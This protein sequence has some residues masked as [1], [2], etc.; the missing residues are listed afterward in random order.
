VKRVLS[1]LAV[2]LMF[3]SLSFVVQAEELSKN[4]R[5]STSPIS[6]SYI[7]YDKNGQ[8]VEEGVVPSNS[9]IS[10]MYIWDGVT[11]DNGESASFVPSHN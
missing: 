2:F 8:I 1:V 5:E 11:L 10:P 6:W 9:S 7:K 3:F 4:K